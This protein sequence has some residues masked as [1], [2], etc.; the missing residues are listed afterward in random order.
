MRNNKKIDILLI[1]I[2]ILMAVSGFLIPVLKS[3]V[4]ISVVHKISS[5]LF[6]VFC[7]MHI[8]QYKRGRREKEN[9]S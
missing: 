7:M 3:W 8:L 1:V 9:V 6:C 2:M 4:W 5:V